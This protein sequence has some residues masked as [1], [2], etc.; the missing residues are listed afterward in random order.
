MQIQSSD[1]SKYDMFIGMDSYNIR[2]MKRIFSDDKQGKVSLL[3]GYTGVKCD[4]ADP[5][6]TEDFEQT[7]RDIVLGCSALLEKLGF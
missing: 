1:Y 5:W 6:Y 3:L 7:E 2:N 4:V